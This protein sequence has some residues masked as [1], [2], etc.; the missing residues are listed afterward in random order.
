MEMKSVIPS[1]KWAY[2]KLAK[3][4]FYRKKKR[5][6]PKRGKVA[7]NSTIRTLGHE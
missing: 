1:L 5:N 4:W 7:Y 2:E 6:N 3:D